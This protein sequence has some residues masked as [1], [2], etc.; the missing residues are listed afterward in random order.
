[1]K[2]YEDVYACWVHRFEESIEDADDWEPFGNME[3]TKENIT[4]ICHHRNVDVYDIHMIYN[5]HGQDIFRKRY[6]TR[7]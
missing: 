4:Y 1:M 7:M 5:E 6:T 3:L 2:S